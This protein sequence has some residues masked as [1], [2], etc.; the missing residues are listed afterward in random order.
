MT[1]ILLLLSILCNTFGLTS[2]SS[3]YNQDIVSRQ[4]GQSNTVQ[5]ANVESKL[6]DISTYPMAQ[7]A[8]VKPKIYAKDYLIADSD[9]GV[10]LLSQGASDRVPIASTTKIMTA[11]IVLENYNLDDVLVVSK[12]GVSTVSEDGAVPDFYTGEKMTVQN[13]LKCMLMNSSNVAAITLAE[14]MNNSDETGVTKFVAKMN[15][16]AKSIGMDNT[17]Y[18]DPA[19]LDVMGYSTAT[20]LLTA[21]KYAMKL[22]LFAQIVGTKQDIVY[23]VSGKYIHQLNN[24]NR[25]VNDWNY[26]GAIGVKTGFMPEAG[27]C[28][29]TAV[30][31]DG[32]TLISIVLNTVA[33]T[34][35]ASAQESRKL[36]DWA[37]QNTTWL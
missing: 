1:Q 14:H 19:G 29:V 33:N 7:S 9:S 28:L 23:D 2:A 6:P 15:E 5:A 4:F 18:R 10:V 12:E 31:R 20:D 8:S 16:K 21:T 30:K 13:L 36:L 35:T 34:P 24:S 32:H 17:N 27:H 25:L 26:P 3:R 37:W 11:T 22:D